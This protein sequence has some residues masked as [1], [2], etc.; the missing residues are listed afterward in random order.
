MSQEL[1]RLIVAV[2]VVALV[3]IAGF[4]AAR[5]AAEAPAAEAL[6]GLSIQCEPSQRAVV[7]RPAPGEAGAVAVECVSETAAVATRVRSSRPLA[8][9]PAVE[10]RLMQAAYAPAPELSQPLVV[11]PAA[12]PVARSAPRAA[13]G[14]SWRTRALVIGGAAGAGA[15]IGGITGGKKGALIGAAIGGGSAALFEAFKKK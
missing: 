2:G 3:A 1:Y 14:R 11:A 9:E 13:Q 15:G 7:H 5:G 8:A 10:T 4:A 6:A 12:A